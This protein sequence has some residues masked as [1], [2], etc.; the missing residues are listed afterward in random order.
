[1]ERKQ[2]N[3]F[4]LDRASRGTDRAKNYK[5]IFLDRDGVVNRDP[6]IFKLRYVT[7]WH[8]FKF[9]PGVKN[10]VRKLTRE[11]YSIYIISNQAGISKGCFT[12]PDLKTITANMVE[13]FE[14][15]GGRITGV[16]YCPHRDEDN[17]GCRKPKAGLFKKAIKKGKIDFTKTFFIGDSMRDIAA[18]RAAGCKTILVLCGKERLK[19]KKNWRI[20][21]DYVK[22]DLL[23]AVN[24]ILKEDKTTK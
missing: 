7:K 11:G 24:W 5:V 10:A 14:K 18:G 22:R 4:L 1:M 23:A 17:C 20:Q 6:G 3:P 8:Y 12:R 9:L 13:E 2:R 16:F 15:A 19:N 21:P